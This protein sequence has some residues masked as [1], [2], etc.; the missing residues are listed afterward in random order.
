MDDQLAGDPPAPVTG[1]GLAVSRILRSGERR[2]AVPV[3]LHLYSASKL[4]F[5]SWVLAMRRSFARDESG[6][7]VFEYL[8]AVTERTRKS[9]PNSQIEELVTLAFEGSRRASWAAQLHLVDVLYDLVQ[10]EF[11]SDAQCMELVRAA[12]IRTDRRARRRWPLRP[13]R[14]GLVPTTGLRSLMG[15]KLKA[16]SAGSRELLEALPDEESDSAVVEVVD[17][18]VV[19]LLEERFPQPPSP[20]RLSG[21]ADRVARISQDIRLDKLLAEEV[22]RDVLVARADGVINAPDGLVV[23]AKIATF[24]QVVEDLGMYPWEVDRVIGA[25]E[26]AAEDAG[27][28]LTKRFDGLGP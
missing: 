17:R 20:E 7:R 5:H 25:A 16:H 12:E 15:Q 21:L 6:R 4:I 27:V 2:H 9:V 8:K 13:R 22:I 19:A 10:K 18:V 14:V 24:V 26:R 28:R 1:A 11:S 3:L 23:H